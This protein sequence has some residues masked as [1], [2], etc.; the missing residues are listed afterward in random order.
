MATDE[1]H[2]LIKHQKKL[3]GDWEQSQIEAQEH[4]CETNRN[5]SHREN[6]E[7]ENTQYSLRN[8]SAC[9]MKVRSK[10]KMLLAVIKGCYSHPF[11]ESLCFKTFFDPII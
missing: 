10:L 9:C 1:H 8:E 4:C 6:P 5:T 11:V 2:P 3:V 7:N